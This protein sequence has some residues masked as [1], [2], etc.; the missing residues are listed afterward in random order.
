MGFHGTPLGENTQVVSQASL[1]YTRR[2]RKDYL[3][4]FILSDS[5]VLM[6]AL[7]G[8][9]GLLQSQKIGNCQRS[10]ISE[11]SDMSPSRLRLQDFGSYSQVLSQ[12]TIYTI[13]GGVWS[14]TNQEVSFFMVLGGT[15]Q[16]TRHQHQ[17]N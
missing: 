9:H 10:T 11:T 12:L 5:K 17:K 8:S 7:C 15:T 16:C 3:F 14:A 6:L 1:I 13:R 4:F 2:A